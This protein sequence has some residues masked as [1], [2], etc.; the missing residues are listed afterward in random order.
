MWWLFPE[1]EEEDEEEQ[2]DDTETEEDDDEGEQEED[3]EPEVEPLQH[4]KDFSSSHIVAQKS[5]MKKI[6]F[7]SIVL[8]LAVGL[9][10]WHFRA[11]I[12][13]GASPSGDTSET[14]GKTGAVTF[15]RVDVQALESRVKELE[16]YQQEDIQ[17]RIRATT[18]LNAL[19]QANPH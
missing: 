12:G 19:L 5:N 11:E 3:D 10:V 16:S 6:V 1:G 8:C 17:W 9:V 4:P 7:L 18:A 15:N 13:I 2:E 14:A